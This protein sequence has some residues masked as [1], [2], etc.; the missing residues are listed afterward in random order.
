VSVFGM[1]RRSNGDEGIPTWVW[2]YLTEG[3]SEVLPG[4]WALKRFIPTEQEALWKKWRDLV[5]SRW[6]AEH[7]GTRPWAWYREECPPDVGREKL[8]GSGQRSAT[9]WEDRRP[10]FHGCLRS[11]P[12][13]IESEASFL[14]RIG[15][16]SPEEEKRIPKKA[17]APAKLEV[18]AE[19]WAA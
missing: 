2:V 12:P 16:L 9:F 4:E 11:D 10:E 19:G 1:T 3:R 6:I 7:P 13:R 14:K 18:D 5:L 17:W 15:V 8:S